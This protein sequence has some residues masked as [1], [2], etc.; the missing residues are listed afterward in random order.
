VPQYVI[1]CRLLAV[2]L[3]CK[4]GLVQLDSGS[5]WKV[6]L[7]SNTELVMRETVTLANGAFTY[8]VI[9]N[10]FCKDCSAYLIVVFSCQRRSE[11]YNHISYHDHS[12]LPELA[13]LASRRSRKPATGPGPSHAHFCVHAISLGPQPSKTAGCA[14]IVSRDQARSR[15]GVL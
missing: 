2:V 12:E 7:E 11:K 14:A 10:A 6:A 1:L 13:R 9:C 4:H 5:A 15:L 3:H 8:V